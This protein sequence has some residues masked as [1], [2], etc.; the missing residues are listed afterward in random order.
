MLGFFI[1]YSIQGEMIRLYKSIQIYHWKYLYV[2]FYLFW[3]VVCRFHEEIEERV[4]KGLILGAFCELFKV[5]F[6]ISS[7]HVDVIPSFSA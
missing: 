6:G 1:H 7:T 3:L 5:G 2:N 4:R